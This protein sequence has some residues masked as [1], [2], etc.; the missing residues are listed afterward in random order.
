MNK[1]IEV[2]QYVN[3]DFSCKVLL[4]TNWIHSVSFTEE[5]RCSI[6]FFQFGENMPTIKT[7]ESYEEICEIIHRSNR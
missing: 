2:T 3:D 6:S 1:F 7:V 5:G 4:N